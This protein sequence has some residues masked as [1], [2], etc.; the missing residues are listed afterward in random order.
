M[1]ISAWDVLSTQIIMIY[2]QESRISTKSQ[3]APTGEDEDPFREVQDAIDN[4]RSV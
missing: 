2:F 3:N 1:L 4:L